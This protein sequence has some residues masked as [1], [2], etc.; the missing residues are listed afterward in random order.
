VNNLIAPDWKLGAGPV[1][2][3]CTTRFGG[4]SHAPYDDGVGGPG[5]NLGQHVGDDAA[6]VNANRARLRMLLP[7]D[8]VWL[9]QVH[10]ANVVDAGAVSGVPDA[11]ASFATSP[12]VVCAVLTADC[13]PVLFSD[14]EG[15]VVAAAHAG[16]RGLA[17]GV[18]GNTV[19]R[20]RTAGAR[21]IQ[22]WLGPAI[23]PRRF[24]V[25]AEV[26]QAFAGLD[27]AARHFALQANGKY[28]ADIYALARLE[29]NACGV[30]L[31]GGGNFCTVEEAPRF[32]SYRR[33]GVTGRMASLIWIDA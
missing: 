33:D 3:L 19:E 24:E 23:G 27:P 29:L 22:A 4:T 9:N 18:L 31:L 7:S 11:D 32:Y 5:L 8:P 26:L 15:R 14:L 28:L 25:G 12:G 10:G 13:L 17:A 1:R 16:W 6:H 2:A 20:M 21:R 30:D